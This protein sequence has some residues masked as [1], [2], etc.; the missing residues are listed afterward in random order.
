MTALHSVQNQG[1]GQDPQ[2][3]LAIQRALPDPSAYAV[4]LLDA[5]LVNHGPADL[6]GR[7]FLHADATVRDLGLRLA[8][9]NDFA[10]LARI[11]EANRDTWYP[12]I[13]AFTAAGGADVHNAYF[14]LI[15]D[16]E[17]VVATV[18]GR[19][20]D[21]PDGLSAHCRS[22]RLMYA[23]P[24]DAQPGEACVLTGEA[25]QAG[26]G[27]RGRVVF[28]G[29][30]WC[31][32]G[33]A[34]GRGLA[35]VIA[36]LSRAYAFSRF[37][38]DWTVSTVRKTMIAG[39]LVRA[40]GY[41]RLAFDFQWRSSLSPGGPATAENP[42]AIV[43]MSRDELIRDLADYVAGATRSSQAAE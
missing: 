15:Y 33:K 28:S 2:P 19:V 4:P 23:D 24:A 41:T 35:S 29:G 20:H 32:P 40:Y 36:R 43:W 9:S 27:I 11:N 17:E 13:P 26:N 3:V 22:L 7:F 30:G 42:V 5:V 10:L 8:F 6:L 21:M 1:A 39:G 31:K 34:R 18:V 12:L 37:G 14:F 25:E 16:A 38:T